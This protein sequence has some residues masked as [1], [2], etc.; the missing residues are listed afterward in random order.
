MDFNL[1]NKLCSIP[2]ISGDEGSIRDFLL[3]YIKE[4]SDSWNV[5]PEIIFGDE[6]QDGIIL[7]FGNPTTAIF[8]H[9]D[10]VGY[11]AGYGVELIKVG[12]PS[13][14]SGTKL[15]GKDSQGEL[16]CTLHRSKEG[17]LTY[18]CD[19]EIDR[20]TCLSYQ[21]NFQ[22]NDSFVETPYLDNRLGVFVA[23]NLAKTLQNGIVAFSCYEETGGGNA[24]VLGR[25]IYE[26]YNVRQALI[27]D[28]TWVT[29]GVQHGNGVAV[30]LRD[31][32]IPR[33][34]FTDKIQDILKKSGCIYQLEVERGGGSDG[35]ALQKTSYPFDWCFIGA[36]EDNVHS[37]CERVSLSDIISMYE[38]YSCLMETL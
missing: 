1:L 2:G 19:R 24:E 13:A 15:V 36:A 29:S 16:V 23:L 30:S 3:T 38:A 12:G 17:E 20:G 35:N 31:S 7:V 27:S 10:T 18:Q 26:K 32:G 21:P 11:T 8:S 6:L 34:K 37:P 25:I 5:Q 9:I 33:K 14:V 4:E 28:I 22:I